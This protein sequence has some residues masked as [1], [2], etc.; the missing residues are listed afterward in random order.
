M[1]GGIDS[2]AA[3]QPTEIR[4]PL[5]IVNCW[6]FREG[7]GEAHRTSVAPPCLV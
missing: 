5:V 7:H 6:K 2:G 3:T 4:R 1:R